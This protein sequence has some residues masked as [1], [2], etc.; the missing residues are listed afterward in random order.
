M[1]T[2]FVS[3]VNNQVWCN[4]DEMKIPDKIYWILVTPWILVAQ[5]WAQY[6]FHII[7]GYYGILWAYMRKV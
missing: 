3:V 4:K 7:G 6:L 5:Y 2:L 1:Y